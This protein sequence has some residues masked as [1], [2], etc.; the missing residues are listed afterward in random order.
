MLSRADIEHVKE[1]AARIEKESYIPDTTTKIGFRMVC[2]PM[3]RT[4]ENVKLYEHV[5]AAGK[6]LCIRSIQRMNP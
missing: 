5:K 6:L 1:I 4:E 3:E 2:V